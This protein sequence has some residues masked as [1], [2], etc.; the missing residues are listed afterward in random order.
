M[1]GDFTIQIFILRIR[2]TVSLYLLSSLILITV[3]SHSLAASPQSVNISTP[4]DSTPKRV[5]EKD[6]RWTFTGEDSRI[7]VQ[8]WEVICDLRLDTAQLRFIHHA[9][10]NE[11]TV[12]NVG[13]LVIDGQQIHN[14]TGQPQ[15]GES[16]N[17]NYVVYNTLGE[18]S[19]LE[20]YVRTQDKLYDE[21]AI[22]LRE[23]HPSLYLLHIPLHGFLSAAVEQYRTLQKQTTDLHIAVN[24][25]SDGYAEHLLTSSEQQEF[26]QAVNM[27][28]LLKRTPLSMLCTNTKPFSESDRKLFQL[29][30]DK[31]L[32][33]NQR[34]PYGDYCLHHIAAAASSEDVRFLLEIGADAGLIDEEDGRGALQYAAINAQFPEISQLLF[35]HGANAL[36]TDYQEN[37]LLHW[38][39]YYA[40][41]DTAAK[42]IQQALALG[43]D[44]DASDADR[45]TPI[46]AAVN[47][48]NV[49]AFRALMQA[50]ASTTLR[51][52]YLADIGEG[53]KVTRNPVTLQAYITDTITSIDNHHG[54]YAGATERELNN[55]KL[56]LFKMLHLLQRHQQT[57]GGK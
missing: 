19:Q 46:F 13:R 33:L 11:S 42:N 35:E 1:P 47:T 44:I 27:V 23:P 52:T 18:G 10:I 54:L 3:F 45:I 43:V 38:I 31:G 26:V 41:G 28:D 14:P 5:I 57:P 39:T 55:T 7:R 34:M 21:D 56:A 40:E 8:D 48:G 30:I 36:A 6:A 4:L 16:V 51:T 12:L 53:E 50:G 25:R 49:E 37:T 17:L 24:L 22:A 2:Q 20:V 29:L 9:D 32:Q 15:L